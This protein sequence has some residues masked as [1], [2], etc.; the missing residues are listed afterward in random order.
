MATL[1]IIDYELKG[2][3]SS[4]PFYSQLSLLSFSKIDSIYCKRV[5][6]KGSV[7]SWAPTERP[8]GADGVSVER[9]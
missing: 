9:S 2:L 5:N 7:G 6:V 8:E 1:T 3:N 4:I